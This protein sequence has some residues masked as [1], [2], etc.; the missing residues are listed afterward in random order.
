MPRK[1]TGAFYF[2]KDDM[3]HIIEGSY[4]LPSKTYRTLCAHVF[5]H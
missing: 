4:I 5:V 2:F 1:V 3:Y